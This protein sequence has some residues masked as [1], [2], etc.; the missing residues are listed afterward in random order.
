M[1]LL[2]FA[3]TSFLLL[4]SFAVCSCLRLWFAVG[5]ADGPAADETAGDRTIAAGSAGCDGGDANGGSGGAAG[6]SG[7]GAVVVVAVAVAD[8]LAVAAA[9]G[10]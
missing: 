5:S 3:V 6:G 4:S 1:L 9:G 8:A 7:A 10:D 2:L